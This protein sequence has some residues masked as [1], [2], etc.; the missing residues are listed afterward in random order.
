MMD[1]M[2]F[3][4][5]AISIGLCLL[6]G[7]PSL[8]LSQTLPELP[9]IPD[10][11]CGTS[12]GHTTL[13]LS[14]GNLQTAI[15]TA[16]PGDTILLE[17]GATFIGPITLKMKPGTGCITI[18]TSAPDSALPPVGQ[19]INPSYTPIMAKI[20]SPGRNQPAIKTDYGAHH[21]RLLGLEVTKQTDS[22]FVSQLIE[23]GDS[24]MTKL[25][26]VP[27]HLELDRLYVH[28]FPTSNLK[29]CIELQSAS[30]TVKNS[31]ISN[32]HVVGQDAQAI[33]GW[34][35]P[36]PYRITNNYL[37]A[38]GENLLFGGADAAIP[39]LVPHDIEITR[40]Y[41]AKPL[42]WRN[43]NTGAAIPNPDWD[44]SNWAVKNLL[45]LKVGI[46]VLI[47]GNILEGSWPDGQSGYSTLFTVRNQDG[48]NPW[49]EIRDVTMTNNIIRHATHGLQMLGQ[50]DNNPSQ[51]TTRILIK[52]NLWLNIG[53]PYTVPGDQGSGR[54]L[55]Y[56]SDV[57]AIQDLTVEHNTFFHSGTVLVP[58]D[59]G[60]NKGVGFTWRN[61]IHSHN[62]Y[63]VLGGSSS[64]GKA[65]LNKYF[66][67]PYGYA[68]N[69]MIANPSPQLYPPDNFNA[70]NLAAVGFTNVTDLKG[71]GTDYSLLPTSPYHKAGTDG[72]D[73]GI[74]WIKLKSAT[75][76]TYSGGIGPTVPPSSPRDLTVR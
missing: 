22:A 69:V 72:T 15:N 13:V 3:T 34:N 27:H 9:E 67:V 73:I 1:H 14:K 57:G 65:T 51:L 40:N 18:R 50:D 54:G 59:T 60:L 12:S 11:S 76:T 45:E 26:Q 32:C 71:S 62:E 16:S 52:N 4:R 6:I 41:I 49:N 2:R 36:G 61:N 64:P 75:V 31:Y 33:A 68:R 63:G 7:E 55:L 21:Y 10:I 24:L 17:A 47:D 44:G 39:N 53:Y 38:S 56:I 20:V 66:A 5:Y 29:R 37:E 48:M 30:T 42:K 46:R 8:T 19:R 25:S 28:G 35:G 70:P 43:P 74:D 58:G 23:L